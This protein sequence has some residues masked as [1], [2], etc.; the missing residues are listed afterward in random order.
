MMVEAEAPEKEDLKEVG[1]CF[2]LFEVPVKELDRRAQTT[3]D[4]MYN[5]I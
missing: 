1:P 4:G 5:I 3:G 2:D